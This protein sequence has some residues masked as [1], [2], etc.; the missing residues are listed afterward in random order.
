MVVP[1]RAHKTFVKLHADCY[2][3]WAV[4]RDGAVNGQ[5]P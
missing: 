3:L 4:V 5:Q 1:S 2:M